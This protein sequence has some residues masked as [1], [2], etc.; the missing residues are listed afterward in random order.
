MS[1]SKNNRPNHNGST[2]Q[3]PQSHTQS[4]QTES[5][6]EKQL[7][8]LQLMID[9]LAQD[10]ID[11]LN[12]PKE[13]SDTLTLSRLRIYAQYLNLYMKFKDKC[14]ASPDEAQKKIKTVKDNHEM[15][16]LNHQ[17]KT[18]MQK[19]KETRDNIDK[20]LKHNKTEQQSALMMPNLT[21][22]I[23]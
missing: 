8:N 12:Q 18:L 14:F 16:E 9:K 5:F 21:Q 7:Q 1:R 17:F 4:S 23:E 2:N 11:N 3:S 22:K 13:D 15:I 6:E 20:A 19:S 10:V